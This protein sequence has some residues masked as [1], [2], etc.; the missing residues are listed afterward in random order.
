MHRNYQAMHATACAPQEKPP[1]REAHT[2]QG[3]QPPLAATR[4]KPMQQ[5]RPNT[6]KSK[7]ISKQIMFK[8]EKDSGVKK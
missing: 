6:A 4:E 7:W 2:L 5:Q 3:E 1:Q 8:K